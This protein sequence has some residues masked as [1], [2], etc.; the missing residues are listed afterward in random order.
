VIVC[1]SV[2]DCVRVRVCDWVGV[3]EAVW[4]AVWEFVE[5]CELDWDGDLV[6]VA[7]ATC[8]RVTAC[9]ERV[10]VQGGAKGGRARKELARTVGRLKKAGAAC[11]DEPETTS[12]SACQTAR[13]SASRKG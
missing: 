13:R 12:E 1:V 6:A 4:E 8:V 11:S 2:R 10:Q 5:P 7:V 3:S 9:N